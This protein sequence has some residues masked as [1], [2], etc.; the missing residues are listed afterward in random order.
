[1]IKLLDYLRKKMK[2]SITYPTMIK[3]IRDTQ[4]AVDDDLNDVSFDDIETF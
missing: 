3:A 2:G 1:M 4:E